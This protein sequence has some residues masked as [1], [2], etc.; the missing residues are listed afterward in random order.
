MKK[1]LLL[2]GLFGFFVFL[3][4]PS[5]A[6][7]CPQISAC[8]CPVQQ[9]CAPA[10]PPQVVYQPRIVSQASTVC[11]PR[12]TCR[13]KSYCQPVIS[14]Q[15]K[16]IYEPR[17]VYEPKSYCQPMISYQ[18]RTCTE[19]M[20]TVEPRTVINQRVVYEPHLACP[21]P[22]IIGAAAPLCCPQQT[23]FWSGVGDFFGF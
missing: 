5:Q 18:T 19:P 8:P 1:F 9:V 10:C 7:C 22:R 3:A 6:Q 23:G 15:S 4:Q 20:M 13:T 17:V 16:T 2:L 12:M 21:Q 14:Y 11:C